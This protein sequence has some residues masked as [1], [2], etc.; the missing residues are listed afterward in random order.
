MCYLDVRR[1]LDS[2][3]HWPSPTEM[4]TKLPTLIPM[5]ETDV[6]AVRD[7]AAEQRQPTKPPAENPSTGKPPEG[8]ELN[9]TTEA[10]TQRSGLVEPG[11]FND[12]CTKI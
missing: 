8:G 2:T 7:L 5:S 1:L 4:I 10:Q 11:M 12:T 9:G 3:L 6:Q